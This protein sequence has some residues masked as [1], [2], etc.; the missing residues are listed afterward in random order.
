MLFNCNET[1]LKL[2]TGKINLLSLKLGFYTLI[3]FIP[4]LVLLAGCTSQKEESEQ[5]RNLVQLEKTTDNLKK[6]LS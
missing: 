6:E 2:K 5:G 3:L 4:V 1:W